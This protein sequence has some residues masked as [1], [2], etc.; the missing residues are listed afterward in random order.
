MT[1]EKIVTRVAR[2]T[3]CSSEVV[4]QIIG[5]TFEVIA[6]AVAGGDKV[7][8]MGFGTFEPKK[9]A[10]RTGR[11]PKTGEAVPIAER[12]AVSFRAGQPLKN[13]VASLP[14]EQ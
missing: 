4:R 14:A 10:A 3:G 8:F 5:C 7:Q 1:K 6:G 2:E 13:A 9:R 11:N 12:M